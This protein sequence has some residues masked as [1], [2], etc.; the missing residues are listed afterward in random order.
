MGLEVL[1]FFIDI[2]FVG[3][4]KSAGRCLHVNGGILGFY[5]PKGGVVF[6]VLRDERNPDDIQK[7]HARH[8]TYLGQN[9]LDLVK[10]LRG[11]GSVLGQGGMLWILVIRSPAV[12]DFLLLSQEVYGPHVLHFHKRSLGPTDLS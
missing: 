5:F 11:G 8:A 2:S 6:L 1:E 7:W 10:Y 4:D 12:H 3:E 9:A